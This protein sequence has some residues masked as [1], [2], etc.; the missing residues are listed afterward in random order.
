MGGGLVKYSW[1]PSGRNPLCAP[2]YLQIS[3]KSLPE[4]RGEGELVVVPLEAELLCHLTVVV[5]V[6]AAVS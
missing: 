4:G 1:H 2:D 6:G 5:A 3:P